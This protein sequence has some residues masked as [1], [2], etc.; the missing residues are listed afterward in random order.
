LAASDRLTI[1]IVQSPM[2]EHRLLLPLMQR[3]AEVL[4]SY[5]L[6]GGFLSGEE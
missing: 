1:S 5:A 6:L 4:V 2:P 3:F